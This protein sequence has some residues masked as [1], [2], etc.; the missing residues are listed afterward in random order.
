MLICRFSLLSA[1]MAS[2]GYGTEII[3]ADVMRF[4]VTPD[5]F[6]QHFFLLFVAR[7]RQTYRNL[8]GIN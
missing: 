1:T 6:K 2:F 5:H 7:L 4:D 8:C 3:D